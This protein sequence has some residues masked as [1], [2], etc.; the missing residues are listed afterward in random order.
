MRDWFK[1]TNIIPSK[2]AFLKMPH[3]KVYNHLVGK[4]IFI[5]GVQIQGS[6]VEHLPIIF[7]I[8][9][10]NVR[11]YEGIYFHIIFTFIE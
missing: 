8:F 5:D 7:Y 4:T 2:D 10:F 9:F 3:F 11:P 1:V 6:H